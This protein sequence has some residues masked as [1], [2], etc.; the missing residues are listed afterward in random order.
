MTRTIRHG[1]MRLLQSM[2]SAANRAEAWL[3]NTGD[4]LSQNL[5]E[6]RRV[7]DTA[8]ETSSQLREAEQHVR[9]T[10]DNIRTSESNVNNAQ[11]SLSSAQSALEDAQ[12]TRERK[13]RE[14]MAVHTGIHLGV[15]ST[16]I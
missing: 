10:E 5:D 14:H 2:Q 4:R 1:R 7:D 9:A 6:A 8:R 12:R 15:G 11:A 16:S 13:E 3:R